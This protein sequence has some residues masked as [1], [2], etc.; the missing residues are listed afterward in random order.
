[1]VEVE[2]LMFETVA[3][4]QHRAVEARQDPDQPVEVH[5]APAAPY[6]VTAIEPQLVLVATLRRAL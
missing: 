5:P 6:L 3:A 2:V 1:V 4:E